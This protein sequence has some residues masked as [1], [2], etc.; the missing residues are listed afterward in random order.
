LFGDRLRV[1]L[2]EMLSSMLQ[3]D[4]AASSNGGVSG[5]HQPC[6]REPAATPVSQRFGERKP[7]RS[8]VAAKSSSPALH[9]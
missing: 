9:E 8:Q 7:P 6:H 4:A 5:R 3:P 1:P 2:G